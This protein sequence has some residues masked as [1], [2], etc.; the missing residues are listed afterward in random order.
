MHVYNFKLDSSGYVFSEIV[1]L[2][3]WYFYNYINILKRYSNAILVKR[4]RWYRWHKTYIFQIFS[5][6]ENFLYQFFSELLHR[7]KLLRISCEFYAWKRDKIKHNN[8]ARRK[9][10]IFMG[11]LHDSMRFLYDYHVKLILHDFRA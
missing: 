6:N 9:H 3:Y 7:E 1:P 2:T 5:N 8:I 4:K 10:T 11:I